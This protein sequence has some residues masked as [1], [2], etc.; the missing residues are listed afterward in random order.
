MK[1]I[2]KLCFSLLFIFLICL[3]LINVTAYSSI[4]NYKPT[5]GTLTANVN[6]R[7]TAS[8]SSGKLRTLSKGTSIKMVGTIDSFY[9]VQLGTN[10]I[11]VVSKSYV[12]SSSTAPKGASTYTT[13]SKNTGTTKSNT[14]LRGGPSTS[15]RKITTL[16]SKTKVTILGYIDNWYIVVTSNNLVGCI[17]KDLLTTASTSTNSSGSTSNNSFSMSENEKT[18][19][20]LI[21]DARA[22]AGISKLVADSNVFK[23]AK[24]KVQDMVKSNYFSH[25]SP[26]Y[27]SPFE[28]L[29]KYGITYKVAGENIAGNPS[30][31]AAVTAWLNSDTHKQNI[32]SNSYNYVG[33][34]V[35]KSDTYGYIITAM[36]IRQI[37]K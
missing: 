1:K 18:I 28:M 11:G 10:E 14:I 6:F 22:K 5:Y 12:K 7:T 19:F 29:K 20:D 17:R 31:E 32:L 4:T 8:T 25:N 34:G 23:V 13:V 27:G 30:L 37:A 24:L 3:S 35:E 2:I 15:F 36:F 33:I 21:N 16:S 26:T 9:I